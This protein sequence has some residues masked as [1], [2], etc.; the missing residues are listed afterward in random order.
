VKARA[1]EARYRGYLIGRQS[2]IHEWGVNNAVMAAKLMDLVI[3]KPTL[4]LGLSAQDANIQS[5]FAAARARMAWDWP[6]HPPAYVFS[7][8]ALGGDQR[9]LLQNVYKD[10][11]TAS[12]REAIFDGALVRAYA[13]PLLSALVLYVL[14]AKLVALVN[15]AATRLAPAERDKLAAGLVAARNAVADSCTPEEA[16]FRALLAKISRALSLFR[17]GMPPS[18]GLGLYH[19]LTTTG[20]HQLPAEPTI[21]GS[22]LGEFAIGAALLGMGLSLGAWTVTAERSVDPRGGVVQLTGS[23]HSA[24]I[25]FAATSQVVHRLKANRVVVDDDEAVIVH[26]LEILL[27][28]PRSPRG[29][30]GRKGR[31]GLREVS[32]STLLA[33][34]S[35]ADGLL[36]RFR[37]KVGL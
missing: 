17:T 31:L 7:E 9:G 25:F 13:K 35:D 23:L 30:R 21:P 33:T 37:E 11:Y 20:V 26:S 2:Q 6:S 18:A 15:I 14:T 34:A 12:N 1:D 27:P 28:M 3:S 10:V 24:K 22:G 8:D 4:M 29:V 16:N 5:L 19:P 32:I 36:Q